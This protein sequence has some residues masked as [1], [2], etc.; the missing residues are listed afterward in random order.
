MK[1][2]VLSALFAIVSLCC[3]AQ[4]VLTPSAGLMTEDGPYTILRNGSESEN[5]DAAKKA[6]EETIPGVEIGDLEYEKSFEASSEYKTHRKLP[7]A[8]IATDWNIKYKMKVESAEGKIFISF[9][10]IGYMEVRR[11]GE[12]MYNIYPTTGRNSMLGDIAGNHFIFNSKGEVAK[13][14]KK[15]K[16]LFEDIANNIVKDIER[17]LK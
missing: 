2:N 15:L 14:C 4:F 10:E 6:V 7:G 13:G 8:F 5:Y 16:E 11:K 3:N 17:N 12:L 1:K 9:E